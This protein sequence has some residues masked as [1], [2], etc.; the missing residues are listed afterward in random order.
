MLTKAWKNQPRTSLSVR[1]TF[2][3]YSLHCYP[4]PQAGI[5]VRRKLHSTF[6]R[7]EIITHSV[8]VKEEDWLYW[9]SCTNWANTLTISFLEW[10]SP[11]P[12]VGKREGVKIAS[13]FQPL[14]LNYAHWDNKK[15]SVI[16]R[17]FIFP[18]CHLNDKNLT[19]LLSQKLYNSANKFNIDF[20][21]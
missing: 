9:N 2:H 17:F 15:E 10:V 13:R 5:G 20:I 8:P 14:V 18:G 6:L 12:A 16:K 7:S 21:E 19:S 1:H 11:W 3:H 4:S